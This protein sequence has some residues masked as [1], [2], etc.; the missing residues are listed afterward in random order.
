MKKN[1]SLLMMLV[2][3]VLVS[4]AVDAQELQIQGQVIQPGQLQ[5]MQG[6]AFSAPSIVGLCADFGLFADGTA[7]PVDFSLAAFDF[8]D[9][10]ESGALR[11][12]ITPGGMGLG[13]SSA[14]IGVTLPASVPAVTVTV[15][16]SSGPIE[17]VAYDANFAL[18]F[19]TTVPAGQALSDVTVQGQGI[20]YVSL[21]GGSSGH[22]QK[23]CVDVLVIGAGN[24]VRPGIESEGGPVFFRVPVEAD[25]P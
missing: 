1:R 9:A 7:F 16:A 6:Q 5:P 3:A 24:V 17:I 21:E 23:I 4:A 19:R 22:L 2:P 8:H 15:G 10:G 11:A 12:G 18:Q 20:L 13:F 25:N 14:G